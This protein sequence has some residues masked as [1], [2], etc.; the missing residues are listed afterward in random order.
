MT[1]VST[2]NDD[3]K[4]FANVQE[5]A[6]QALAHFQAA[7]AADPTNVA[8]QEAI[9]YTGAAAAR[10]GAARDAADAALAKERHDPLLYVLRGQAEATLAELD[11]VKA[12]DNIGPAMMAFDRVA[13]MDPT[14]ALPLLQAASVAL[15]VDR[16]DLVDSHLTKA[17]ALKQCRLYQ[18]PIPT[19][20][21][22]DKGESLVT[23]EQIQVGLWSR[24]CR[25]ARTSTIGCCALVARRSARETSRPP[26]SGIGKLTRS[27]AWWDRASRACSLRSGRRWTCWAATMTRWVGWPVCN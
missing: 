2:K 18:L 26:R 27:P 15:D 16:L 8:Y 20:L 4:P 17:L 1:Y 6:E 22:A 14:N 19:D 5:R 9:A 7:A 25:A 3:G 13:E 23:W 12:G 24:F 11:P 21:K 10:Y